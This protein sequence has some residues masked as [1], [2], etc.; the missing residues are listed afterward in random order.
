MRSEKELGPVGHGGEAGGEE[1]L[2]GSS[3]YIIPALV[4]IGIIIGFMIG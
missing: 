1:I 2:S 4:V 3:K